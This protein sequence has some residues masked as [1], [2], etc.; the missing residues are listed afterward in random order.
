ME[1]DDR[2]LVHRSLEGDTD[3]FGRLVDR[4]QSAVFATAYYYAGRHGAAEDITQ[5]AFLEAF[6]SLRRLKDPGVFG[7]WLKEIACRTAANWVRRHG[8][9]FRAETPLPYR[10]AVSIEDARH[11]PQQAMEREELY[12]RVRKAVD[13]LPEQYRLPIVLRYLQE[14]SYA[15]IA[16]FTGQ[17]RDEVRGLLQRGGSLLRDIL[18]PA[19]ERGESS[20]HRARE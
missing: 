16:H 5:E 3:A 18:E 13:A 7:P 2:Y 4:Y 1:N 19:D 15:E 10:R 20:W 8:K 12:D 11:G 9:R 14:Q 6:R 17:S